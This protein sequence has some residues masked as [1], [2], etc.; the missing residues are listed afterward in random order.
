MGEGAQE[1]FDTFGKTFQVVKTQRGINI[2]YF[3][4]DI[5]KKSQLGM[6]QSGFMLYNGNFIYLGVQVE[7]DDPRFELLA[8][9]GVKS[10][11][12]L[13]SMT[14]QIESDKLPFAKGEEEE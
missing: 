14:M 1:L 5:R 3:G 11:V 7:E 2:Q 4:L 12:H 13:P 6:L 10:I 8:A 9:A